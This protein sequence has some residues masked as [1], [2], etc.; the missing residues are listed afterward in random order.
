MR[1]RSKSLWMHILCRI[2]FRLQIWG[3]IPNWDEMA[4]LQWSRENDLGLTQRENAFFSRGNDL[5]RGSKI[6]KLMKVKVVFN[7]LWGWKHCRRLDKTS[8]LRNRKCI[9]KHLLFSCIILCLRN[10][11]YNK[12]SKIKTML[13]GSSSLIMRLPKLSFKMLLKYLLNRLKK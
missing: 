1:K 8:M 6:H 10:L 3:V 12:M 5:Y 11:A 7:E 9:K 4:K 2:R 13:T